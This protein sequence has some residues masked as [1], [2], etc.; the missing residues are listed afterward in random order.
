MQGVLQCVFIKDGNVSHYRTIHYNP[1]KMLQ[2]ITQLLLGS[3][4]SSSFA[5]SPM[6]DFCSFS[7]STAVS[8]SR[9]D[10]RLLVVLFQYRLDRLAETF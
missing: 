3:I 6:Y 4:V 2:K 7:T 5:L 1:F 9:L 10:I 8:I